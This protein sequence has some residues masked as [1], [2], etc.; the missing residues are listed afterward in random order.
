M[1]YS[2]KQLLLNLNFLINVPTLDK[3][4]MCRRYF[5]SADKIESIHTL[6]NRESMPVRHRFGLNSY[7]ETL[8]NSQSS[9]GK[10]MATGTFTHSS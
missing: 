7:D 1:T 3:C 2:Q 6:F 4:S 9:V 5:S 10:K 8:D